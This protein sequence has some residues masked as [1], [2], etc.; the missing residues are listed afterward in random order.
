MMG[1]YIYDPVLY[2]LYNS[3]RYNYGIFLFYL[4]HDP[5]YITNSFL[6]LYVYLTTIFKALACA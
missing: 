1:I 4:Y 6:I 2:N 3:F 5:V